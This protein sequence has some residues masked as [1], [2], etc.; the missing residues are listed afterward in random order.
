MSG[1][2]LLHRCDYPRRA[3]AERLVLHLHSLDPR[4]LLELL[5][6]LGRARSIKA[7]ALPLRFLDK[8][9]A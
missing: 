3:R 1:A 4:V 6:E 8:D 2:E 7:N 5:L 9:A